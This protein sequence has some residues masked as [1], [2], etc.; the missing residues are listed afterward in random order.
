MQTLNLKNFLS[1]PLKSALERAHDSI[2]ALIRNQSVY[3]AAI[4]DFAYDYKKKWTRQGFRCRLM[5]A[6]LFNPIKRRFSK[7]L[8]LIYTSGAPLLPATSVFLR[9][10]LSVEMTFCYGTTET[11][12][13]ACATYDQFDHRNAVRFFSFLRQQQ[14]Y[15]LID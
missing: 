7:R 3:Q 9:M 4:H 1:T 8:E 5:D 12:A 2:K 13:A 15:F 10:Y 11:M 14:Y 6:L